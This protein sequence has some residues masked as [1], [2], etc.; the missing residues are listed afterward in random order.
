MKRVKVIIHPGHGGSDPGAVAFG[1][2]EKDLN[3][4]YSR[5]L[6]AKLDELPEV[7]VDLSLVNDKIY[8]P[9][10]LAE[11]VKKSGASICISCHN[12]S[13]DGNARGFEV[14]H[15][16]HSDGRLAGY[17]LNE[18]KKTGFNI[19]RAYSRESRENP[20]Q[21]LYYIIRLTYPQVETVIVEFGFMDNKDD[22]IMLTNPVWQEKL[23]SAVARAVSKYI[24][25]SSEIS[26]TGRAVLTRNQ[27]KSALK[28]HNPNADT[29]IVDIYY[30]IAKIYGIKADMAFLQSMLETNWLK[31][32]GTV[33]GRQNNFAGLGATGKGNPGETFPTV[34]AGVEAHIQHLFAYAT[35]KPLPKG[36]RLYD[37]R[38][39]LVKRGSASNWKDLNGRWAVPGTN[40]GQQIVEMHKKVLKNFPNK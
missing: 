34:E 17:I 7:E 40:Y 10:E 25:S 30:E 11:K 16:I 28:H 6:S 19:R 8:S 4:I 36:R 27:L 20:G 38:F 32:T 18:V 31:F 1:T 23:A 35:A 33:K 3:I 39:N 9:S 14:I 21:D 15:S 13:F 26:I 2:T 24:R 37:T 5:L 12:N 29:S 22:Y